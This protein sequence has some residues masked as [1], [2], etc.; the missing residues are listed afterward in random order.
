MALKKQIAKIQQIDNVP[1][2]FELASVHRNNAYRGERTQKTDREIR[3]LYAAV[4]F[5]LFVQQGKKIVYFR[6]RE[7]SSIYS[8]DIDQSSKT[9]GSDGVVFGS[10][11][12]GQQ[13]H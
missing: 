12:R 6:S 9:V 2:V 3:L 10:K 4:I 5:V 8:N 11:R 7:S 13:V 1:V